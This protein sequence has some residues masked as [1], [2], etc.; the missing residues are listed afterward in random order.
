M[1]KYPVVLSAVLAAGLFV[2]PPR[3]SLAAQDAMP[4]AADAAAIRGDGRQRAA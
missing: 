3:E 1:S 2:Q 4:T